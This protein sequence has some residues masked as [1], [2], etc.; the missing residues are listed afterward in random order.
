MTPEIQPKK[1]PSVVVRFVLCLLILTLGIGGFIILKKMK[2]SPPER[3]VAQAVLPVEVINVHPQNFP[4]TIYGYGDVKARTRVTLSAEVSGRVLRKAAHLLAGSVV[5]RGDI[6]FEID[7]KDYQLELE[8]AKSRLA[9]L[10]RDLAIAGAELKRVDTLRR[11]NRVGSISSVDKAESA[12]NAI[13]NQIAQVRKTKD[14]AEIQLGRCLLRAPFTGRVGWTG[15][16]ADEYVTP[17]TKMITL[18]DDSTLEVKVPLD[19]RDASRWLR[20]RAR[21]Q[22]GDQHW[23][24]RPEPV[25]CE[26]IWSEDASVRATGTVDRIVSFD[27]KTRMIE[28]AVILEREKKTPVPLVDGMFSRVTIPGRVLHDVYI[29]PRQAVSFTGMV[30]VVTAGR[31]HSRKVEVVRE[32][33]DIAVIDKGLAPGDVVITTR[34]EEPLDNTLVRVVGKK[35]Q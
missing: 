26:V 32:E 7:G 28:V 22:T 17:G 1:T 16:E 19:S 8:T 4:V 6:L 34:L 21:K 9:V 25:S 14:R 15:V 20:L 13:R 33:T 18:I 2:K 30:Y 29:V 24:A 23:F 5:N 27:P 11:K 12:V 10:A 3:P 31:L 35:E